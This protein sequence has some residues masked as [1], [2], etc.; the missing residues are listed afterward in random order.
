MKTSSE[1]GGGA[2]LAQP[3]SERAAQRRRMVQLL[4]EE[5]IMV[6]LGDGGGW[7]DVSRG[8]TAV[9][10]K[11][12]QP[13]HAATPSARQQPSTITSAASALLS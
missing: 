7:I 12:A 11:P 5:E 8:A 2:G 4:S 6:L 3:G 9:G 1:G 10:F 13:T